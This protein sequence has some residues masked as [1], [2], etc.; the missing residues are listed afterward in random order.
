MG[1]LVKQ[2]F[3]SVNGI[4][5]SVNGQ[6]TTVN[7]LLDLISIHSIASAQVQRNRKNS[8]A[9]YGDIIAGPGW[10][11]RVDQFI[12]I[13]NLVTDIITTIACKYKFF[14]TSYNCSLV[15]IRT[16]ERSALAKGCLL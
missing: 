13:V 5:Y 12:V 7:D 2:P 1:C 6:R 4:R 15:R 16:E 14:T 10:R 11:T 9:G 8:G 3:Y